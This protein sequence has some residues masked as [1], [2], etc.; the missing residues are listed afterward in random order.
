[1]S[2][3]IHSRDKS[4]QTLKSVWKLHKYTAASPGGNAFK[5]MMPKKLAKT[6]DQKTDKNLR[7]IVCTNIWYSGYNGHFLMEWKIAHRCYFYFTSQAEGCQHRMAPLVLVTD[8]MVSCKIHIKM[9]IKSST[10][11][12]RQSKWFIHTKHYVHHIHCQKYISHVIA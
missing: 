2:C 8:G 6:F 9:Y 11:L 3:G 5:F 10:K 1:M 4:H 7:S 12:S